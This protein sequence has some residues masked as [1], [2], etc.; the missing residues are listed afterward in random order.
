LRA[1]TYPS[2]TSERIE[3]LVLV[4]H[5]LPVGQAKCHGAGSVRSLE[6]GA[7]LSDGD[8]AGPKFMLHDC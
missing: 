4:P 5:L 7:T 2:L 8:G 6:I 1:V 3:G